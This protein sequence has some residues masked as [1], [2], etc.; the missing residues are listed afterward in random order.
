[1]IVF[2]RVA[3]ICWQLSAIVPLVICIEDSFL[4]LLN[5]GLIMSWVTHLTYWCMGQFLVSI[6]FVETDFLL[7]KT[8]M[9]IEFFFRQ[10]VATCLNFGKVVTLS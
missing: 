9:P 10:K 2:Y 5:L 8:N 6:Q 3:M 4:S 7:F 1:M